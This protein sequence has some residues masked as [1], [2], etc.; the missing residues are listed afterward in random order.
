MNKF[1]FRHFIART[2]IDEVTLQGFEIDSKFLVSSNFSVFGSVGLV[3]SEIDKNTNR[4]YTEGNDM[5]LTPDMTAN[6][7]AEW[8]S[9]V[10]SATDLVVRLDW[11]YV[12]E[13]WF[14]TVQENVTLNAFTNV[15]DTYQLIGVVFGDVTQTPP[16][17]GIP[18]DG[19]LGF[20]TSE[21]SKGR[22]DSY[23]T[24][25]LN[26]SLKAENWTLTFWGNN[27]LD[28]EYIEEVIP[29]PEFGGYFIHPA[30]G[31]V[32]GIDFTYRFGGN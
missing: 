25:N 4:P 14:S 28:E 22:R 32:F 16:G 23:S 9:E 27:I 12:G 13:T 7:G 3:D 30:R 10:F 2:N 5:P 8:V 17:P 19:I 20:G 6:L 21:Y 11:R 29:A 18:A 31:E 1:S 15:S 26:I 24:L